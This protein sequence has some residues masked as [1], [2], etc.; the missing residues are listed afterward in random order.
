MSLDYLPFSNASAVLLFPSSSSFLLAPHNFYHLGPF[1]QAGWYILLIP[2]IIVWRACPSPSPKDPQ[3]VPDYL[4]CTACLDS[5][6]SLLRVLSHLDRISGMHCLNPATSSSFFFLHKTIS[7][8]LL[9]PAVYTMLYL[10][11]V[12]LRHGF[13][14]VGPRSL[15]ARTTF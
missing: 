12:Y 6:M 7:L 5:D 9:Q 10:F 4:V 15:Q 2:E 14:V 13:R 3:P 8:N 11:Q 1:A